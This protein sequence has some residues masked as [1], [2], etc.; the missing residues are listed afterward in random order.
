[1]TIRFFAG[2]LIRFLFIEDFQARWSCER[3]RHQVPALEREGFGVADSGS[4]L[5]NGLIQAQP[6]KTDKGLASRVEVR[7][8]HPRGE[9]AGVGLNGVDWA[10]DRFRVI[11]YVHNFS[12]LYF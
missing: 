11:I 10:P 2:P 6:T 8:G 1:M 7:L 12:H 5:D 4:A 9:A 3:V